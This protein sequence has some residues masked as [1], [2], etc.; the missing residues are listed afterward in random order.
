MFIWTKLRRRVY[1]VWDDSDIC[2]FEDV[3]PVEHATDG[4]FLYTAEVVLP[5]DI[6][7]A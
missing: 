3:C 4:R 1:E 2:D 5:D 6:D 7:R